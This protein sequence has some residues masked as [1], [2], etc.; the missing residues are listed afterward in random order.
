MTTTHPPA[1]PEYADLHTQAAASV[2]AD[3]HFVDPAKLHRWQNL[4][5]DSDWTISVIGH[6]R[7]PSLVEMHMLLL[8]DDRNLQ[9]PLPQWL[10]D[11]R[12]EQRRQAA[13]QQAAY[14]A[15]MTAL[16]DEW[17]ALWKALPVPITVAYNYSG[18]NHLETWTQGA[19]HI[20]LG[21]ELHVGRL[22]RVAGWALCTVS[23]NVKHQD[24]GGGGVPPESR[25]PTCKA[26]L[27]TASRLTGRDVSTLLSTR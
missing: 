3:G 2:A 27:R 23:S 21:E 18:P 19:V 7:P 20:I 11:R 22:H 6:N 1:Y 5:R 12:A 24:F 15:R 26:C 25:W 10:A 4:H 17:T 9:P 8:A 13:A 14:Q 16:E